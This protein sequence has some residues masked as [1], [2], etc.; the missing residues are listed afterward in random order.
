MKTKLALILAIIAL[1]SY[2]YLNPQSK[3]QQ[4]S[5]E[6]NKVTDFKQN[7]TLPEAMLFENQSRE[8]PSGANAP[9]GALNNERLLQF[10]SA[11]ELQSFLQSSEGSNLTIL[12]HNSHTNTLRVG[13]RNYRDLAQLLPAGV[14]SL[15]NFP[16]TPPPP[17]TEGSLSP[18]AR[19]F[20]GRV[21][22]WL[23][24]T[25]DNSQWGAGVQVAVLDSGI[26]DHPALA[27][28]TALSLVDSGVT[29]AHGTAMTSLWRS[30]DGNIPA[31]APAVDLTSIQVT[32]ESGTSD[33]FTLA[34][35][36]FLAVDQGA[37]LIPI[38]LGST[39]T[40]PLLESAIAYAV[41]NDALIIASAG[42]SGDDTP[43]YPAAYTDTLSIAAL[44]FNRNYPGFSTTGDTISLAAP[45]VGL[46]A[47][48][49]NGD[50]SLS[51]GTS[52]AAQIAGNVIA[53]TMSELE[54][55]SP[56]DAWE[57]VSNNLN[58]LGVSGQDNIFGL[59]YPQLDVILNHEQPNR[60]DGAIAST[61]YNA[62]DDAVQIVVS[63]PG[64]ENLAGASLSF[65]VA[66][67]SFTTP[68][69]EIEVGASHDF[70]IPLDIPANTETVTIRSEVLL[71]AGLEDVRPRDNGLT[72]RF[73][74]SP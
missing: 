60:Y 67:Q 25:G 41:E 1:V 45:G 28:V 8:R 2:I 9:E 48:N 18:N 17:I 36:I 46:V 71:P 54:I 13:F 30:A 22:E 16:V 5:E 47:A 33:L 63:N 12:G 14:D 19:P 31:I 40:N 20:Q 3:P 57:V 66:G 74:L 53:A 61:V 23:G 56:Y 72:A 43:Y 7:Q 44:D 68:L 42:N 4:A 37:Q 64:T 10:K 38:S 65:E 52:P 26:Y 58:E 73:E 34:E 39:S 27:G 21:K 51:T 29:T 24:I 6:E 55:A 11:A 32:G 35:G 70:T 49:E 69:P 15:F 62:A 50:Y 59:G